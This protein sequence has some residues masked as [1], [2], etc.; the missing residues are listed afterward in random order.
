LVHQDWSS[1][2]RLTA[3]GRNRLSVPARQAIADKQI[4]PGDSVLDFGCGRG[5]D[6]RALQEMGCE[7]TGWDPFYEPNTHLDR[8]HVVLLT[9]I[10]NVIEDPEERRRALER[11]WEL[12]GTV[13]IVSA[14]LTWERSKVTGSNFN[15]GLLTS[16]GTFQR[17]F[18]AREL[19]SYVEDVTG[20]RAVSASPGIIYTF[21]DERARLGYLA[22]RVISDEQWLASGDTMSA[23]AALIDYVERRGRLPQL[24]EMP[25]SIAQLLAHPRQSEIRRLVRDS[26]AHDKVS[27]GAKRTTLNTLL[28]LAVELFHGRGPFSSLPSSAQLDIRAFFSSY[29]EAC[30]R[31]DRL[32]FKLRD[33][34]YIRGAMNASAVGKVTPTAFYVHRRALEQMPTVLRL[35]EHCASIAAGRPQSWTVAKLR[36]QGRL[37]SWLDY[38]DFDSDPHPRLL[39][40]YQVDLGTLETEH[41]SH[42]DSDDRP[43]LHRKQ[44][45][46][47]P[48]DP[49]AA[50]YLRLSRLETQAGLYDNPH[51]IGSESGW[52]QELARCGRALRGHRLVRA[53]D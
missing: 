47:H 33:D 25:L 44:E 8:S 15:D 3:I 52:A 39:S 16:R 32:L 12:A 18:E 23:I 29:K 6:V 9:Y 35:Y 17:L 40:S 36:H 7:A 19:R 45:F 31:A 43:L 10:L 27:H 42:H 28:F 1:D 21:K 53:R 37:V 4:L 14:R 11:A 13:L 2:R 46:L 20:I 49:D 50:R 48:E 5:G 51:L 41:Q 22:Q 38:P 24:E 26:A 34:A 30:W